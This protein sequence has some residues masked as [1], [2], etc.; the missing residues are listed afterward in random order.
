MLRRIAIAVVLAVV[1]LPAMAVDL[2]DQMTDLVG[3]LDSETT[4]CNFLQ[5]MCR[6]AG[7]SIDLADGTP[8]SRDFLATR[9]GLLA[10]T[11]VREAVAAA[12]AIERKRGKRLPCFDQDNCRGILPKSLD[13]SAR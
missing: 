1:V 6:A 4:E 2:D 11:R 13:R 9:Q 8:P 7:T 10:D 12:Q 3:G 5:A